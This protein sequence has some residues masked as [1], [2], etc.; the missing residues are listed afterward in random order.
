[1]RRVVYLMRAWKI[2]MPVGWVWWRSPLKPDFE[3][4]ASGYAPVN[5]Q[6]ITVVGE[7]L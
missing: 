3:G 2:E 4:E 7:G 1:M 5:L 6:D